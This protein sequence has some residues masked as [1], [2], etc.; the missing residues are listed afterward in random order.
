MSDILRISGGG[1]D[2]G[3]EGRQSPYRDPDELLRASIYLKHE[4]AHLG[5]LS[6]PQLRV[7]ERVMQ[8][9]ANHVGGGSDYT[10]DR[11]P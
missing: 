8:S 1:L 3:G 6:E 11:Q 10:E 9:L 4:C 5:I 2:L 7:F